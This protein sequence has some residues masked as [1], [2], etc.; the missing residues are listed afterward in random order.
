M[1]STVYPVG[2]GMEDWGY[3][4]GW[5]NKTDAG[6]NQCR[7]QTK[8]ALPDSFFESQE[9]VRAAVYLIEADN[10]KD[11]AESTFGARNIVMN[12]ADDSF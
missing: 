7:P 3:G 1:T 4:G 2:G 9:Q 8:P 11:P 6:F 5:D 10:F 12:D